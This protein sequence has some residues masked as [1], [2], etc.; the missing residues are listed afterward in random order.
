MSEDH[1]S[2]AVALQAE[3]VQGLPKPIVTNT[4][5]LL[6]INLVLLEKVKVLVPLVADNLEKRDVIFSNSPCRR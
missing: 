3:H 6:G 2:A 1:S 5:N 4:S